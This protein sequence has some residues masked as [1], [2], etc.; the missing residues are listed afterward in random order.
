MIY[1]RRLGDLMIHSMAIYGF[2]DPAKIHRFLDFT[3]EHSTIDKKSG[4]VIWGGIQAGY[5]DPDSDATID[6]YYK[7]KV[8]DKGCQAN[9]TLMSKG[10]LSPTYSH[11]PDRLNGKVALKTIT[12]GRVELPGRGILSG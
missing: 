1:R 11:L 7:N 4:C 5:D 9:L 6:A 8:S 3:Y 12:A 10:S 2:A